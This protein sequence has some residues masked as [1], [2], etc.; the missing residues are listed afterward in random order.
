MFATTFLGHQG[1]LLRTER[2]S[3]LVD[4]LLCEDFG[5]A[6]ALDYRLY[7]PRVLDAAAFPPIDAVFLSHE[8]D[9]HF[10][11]PSLARLDRKIPIFLS[12][13]SSS[14]ARDILEAMGFVVR[15]LVPGVRIQQGD[16]EIVPFAGDHL[17]TNVS[18]EWDTLP[19]SIRQTDGEGSFF[20]MVDITLTARHLAWAKAHV[21]A[22][23][24]VTWTNN[25]LDLSHMAA[26]L[27]EECDAT[28]RSARAMH[29]GHELIGK[30]WGAPA[31]ML[32]CA[33]GFAFHGDRAWLNERVFSVDADA[34]CEEMSR[35][36]AHG[37]FVAA[38]PGQTFWM[39]RGQLVR[40]DETTAFLRPMP[41]DQWPLRKK[42]SSTVVR[43][44]A[45]ATGRR[46]L[47][48][49]ERE[50]LETALD[51]FA[52]TLVG[53]ITFKS[54]HSL[55]VTEAPGRELTFAFA[56]RH[57]DSGERLVF[58][59]APSSCSFRPSA[60]RDPEGTYVAG[61][62][63]WASDLLA[64]FRGEL[65]PIGIMFGRAT[66]WNAL[67]QRLRF[68]LFEDLYRVSHPLSRP[69]AFLRTYTALWKRVAATS[70]VILAPTAAMPANVVL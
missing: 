6:H 56:L 37:R 34:V 19:L 11:I 66:L 50:Q 35:T 69:A 15:P 43:D 9:D 64:V 46:A 22:P 51:G 2:T 38:R 14:A 47:S 59:Y 20:T 40:V 17:A 68:D 58:E 67:P 18:D 48:S 42:A 16:L 4:P 26:Y 1:W 45:P 62:A 25:A 24:I 55:L 60:S 33:G 32:M 3:W 12:A 65:G 7:P 5:H 49:E 27:P 54:L 28:P 39:E 63:C 21:R 44:Y 31:A 36:H 61:L 10:D 70:P 13:R 23:G 57:G 53:G 41:R 8:H 29:A 52:G 30:E